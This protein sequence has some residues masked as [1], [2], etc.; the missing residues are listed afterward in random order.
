MD[1][2]DSSLYVFN[3]HIEADEAMLQRA[4]VTAVSVEANQS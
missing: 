4:D 2:I 3:T 1:A